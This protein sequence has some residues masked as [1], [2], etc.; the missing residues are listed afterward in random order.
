MTTA[1]AEAAEQAVE[2]RLRRPPLNGKA[3][4]RRGYRFRVLYQVSSQEVRI[5]AVLHGA[6][7]F[8]RWLRHA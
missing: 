8:E 6:M 3:F 2:G 4:E 7:D 5:L 1:G